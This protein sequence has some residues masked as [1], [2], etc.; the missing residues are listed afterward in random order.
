MRG[1]IIFDKLQY[2]TH[3]EDQMFFL[4]ANTCIVPNHSP[5]EF[6]ISTS[7]LLS[8][9]STE[10]QKTFKILFFCKIIYFLKLNL[11]YSDH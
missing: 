10:L 9:S 4:Y 6:S 8:P 7:Y 11:I 3:N 5:S 2:E 1:S